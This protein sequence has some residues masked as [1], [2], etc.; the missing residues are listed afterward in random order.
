M[1]LRDEIQKWSMKCED[2]KGTYLDKEGDLYINAVKA[3]RQS[4]ISVI[5]MIHRIKNKNYTFREVNTMKLDGLRSGTIIVTDNSALTVAKLIKH[6]ITNTVVLDFE[7]ILNLTATDHRAIHKELTNTKNAIK[8]IVVFINAQ[9]IDANN[10]RKLTYIANSMIDKKVIIIT[11]RDSVENAK[12]Y[13]SP[14]GN[15]IKDE[16]KLIDLS[17]ESQKRILEN[18]KVIF[19]GE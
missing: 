16:I 13:F 2:G 19:Q 14:S 9:N 17:E 6:N 15:V 5:N 8:L 12:K 11:D 1:I 10:S 18:T 3:A 4:L 7:C